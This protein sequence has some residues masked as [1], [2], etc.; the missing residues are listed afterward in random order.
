MA[1]LF[2]FS[3]GVACQTGGTT[4][5]TFV[6]GRIFAGLGIG[7]TSCLV[8]VCVGGLLSLISRV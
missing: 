5:R 8:P 1:F 2:L 3:I 4:L 6:V 7:G